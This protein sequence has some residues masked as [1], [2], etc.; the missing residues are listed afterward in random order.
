M[1]PEE[2]W[3]SLEPQVEELILMLDGQVIRRR[4]EKDLFFLGR[5]GKQSHIEQ[6]AASLALCVPDPI[7]FVDAPPGDP[8]HPKPLSKKNYAAPRQSFKGRMRSVNR[9]K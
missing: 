5:Y 8:W 7:C 1:T 4:A 3:K 2:L 6:I 9:N